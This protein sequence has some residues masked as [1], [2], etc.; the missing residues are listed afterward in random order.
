MDETSE[1]IRRRYNRAAYF[2]DLLEKPMEMMA[3][4]KWRMERMKYLRGKVL[5]V[6]VYTGKNRAIS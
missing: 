6:G 1:K 3:L 2:Y 5:E 4:K